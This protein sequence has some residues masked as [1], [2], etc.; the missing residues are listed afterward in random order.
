MDTRHKRIPIPQTSGYGTGYAGDVGYV[1]DACPLQIPGG[2]LGD[3]GD[4]RR[5][6]IPGLV[7][8]MRRMLGRRILLRLQTSRRM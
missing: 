4:A 2:G 6:Q 5:S 1:G 7:W 8:K 3:S